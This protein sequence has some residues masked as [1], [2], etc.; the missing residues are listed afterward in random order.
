MLPGRVVQHYL[1]HLFIKELETGGRELKRRSTKW[2]KG[3]GEK[4]PTTK[5][6]KLPFNRDIK[7]LRMIDAS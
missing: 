4:M 1:K 6:K 2:T 7:G 3:G 5:I